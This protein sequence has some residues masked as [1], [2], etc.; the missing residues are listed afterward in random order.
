MQCDSTP[1]VEGLMSSRRPLALEPG[2]SDCI[3]QGVL[4]GP[5]AELYSLQLLRDVGIG[6][7]NP[8]GV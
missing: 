1:E 5:V 2:P 6:G 4:V 3:R 7:T 8:R